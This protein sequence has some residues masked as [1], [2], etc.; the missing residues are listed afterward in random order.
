MGGSGAHKADA[1]LLG[2]EQPLFSL[3]AFYLAAPSPLFPNPLP[4]SCIYQVILP[5]EPKAF[6]IKTNKLKAILTFPLPKHNAGNLPHI[7]KLAMSSG[8]YT[9]IASSLCVLPT[10]FLHNDIA[11]SDKNEGRNTEMRDISILRPYI[12]LLN[13]LS[14]FLL[15]SPSFQRAYCKYGKCDASS[16]QTRPIIPSYDL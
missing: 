13:G 10:T 16:Y 11:E 8:T 4:P 1:Y 3:T 14:L 5:P 7:L 6:L 15:R 12:F 9:H 2:G